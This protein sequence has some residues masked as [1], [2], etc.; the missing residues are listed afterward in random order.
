MHV[1]P[2]L[3][4]QAYPRARPTEYDSL[5]CMDALD[6]NIGD[7]GAVALVEALKGMPDLKELHLNSEFSSS[8]S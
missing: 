5:V 2:P 3:S 1:S 8:Y 7:G 4:Y 6:N